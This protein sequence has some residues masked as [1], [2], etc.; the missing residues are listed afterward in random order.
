M[1]V[2]AGGD[3]RGFYL[4]FVEDVPNRVRDRIQLHNLAVND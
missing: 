4:V 3:F 2:D 1:A